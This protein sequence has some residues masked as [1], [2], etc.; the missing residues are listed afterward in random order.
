MWA[1]LSSRI[2][3]N[4]QG[5]IQKECQVSIQLLTLLSPQHIDKLIDNLE[6]RGIAEFDDALDFAF[7][8]FNQV[9]KFLNSNFNAFLSPPFSSV[10]PFDLFESDVYFLVCL[11]LSLNNKLMH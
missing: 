4:T 10:I 9:C 6:A 8:T 3:H 7:Y 1:S 11:R 5:F 2:Y